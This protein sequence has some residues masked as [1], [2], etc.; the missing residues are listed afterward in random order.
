MPRRLRLFFSTLGLG[1][2]TAGALVA[3][4]PAAPTPVA[5]QAYADQAEQELRNNILP[6]WLTQARDRAHGGFYG[7]ITNDLKIDR[8]A[9]RGLLLTARILWTFSAAYRRYQDPTYLEMAR[10]AYADLTERFLDRTHGGFYWSLDANQRPRDL[11]K[12]TYGQAF[13]IYALSEY[14][15]ATG[16]P[17]ARDLASATYRLL[18]ASSRDPVYGGYFETCTRDWQRLTTADARIMGVSTAKSQN[19]NLHVM[20]AFTALLR[21]WPDDTIRRSQR[22]MIEVVLTRILDPRTHHLILLAEAD[23]TPC[24]AAISY[25]H[26]IEVSWLLTEAA[27]ICGDP[28]VLARVRPV[29]VAIAR[30]TLAE[31]VDTDGG[32]WNE[33][34]PGRVTDATKEWWPQAE[35]TVGFL[36]AYQISGNPQ[37]FA[38]SLH[39]WAFIQQNLVDR[40]Y[41]EWLRVATTNTRLRARHPKLSFWKCPYHNGRACLELIGRL[42]LLAEEPAPARAK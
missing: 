28:A 40:K 37:F 39:S 3:Q 17:A 24:G 38:A 14:A 29:A 41:G 6:F 23:W 16:E 10:W 27:E 25:G 34:A 30:A 13:A 5:L 4:S 31:G 42:R 32:V 26:D 18:D 12:Q 36:N 21:I 8:T 7:E 11:R 22:A 33:G 19:T 20:E 1:L 35:A 15:R 2:L 9:P